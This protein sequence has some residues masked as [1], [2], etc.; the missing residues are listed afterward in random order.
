MNLGFCKDCR[1][2]Q[3]CI[4][5]SVCSHDGKPFVCRPK[6]NS[7]CQY[8]PFPNSEPIAISARQRNWDPL[9]YYR[10]LKTYGFDRIV[11]GLLLRLTGKMPSIKVVPASQVVSQDQ[12]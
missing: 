4:E 11:M 10:Y 6:E 8:S 1:Q 9:E 5:A 12:S 3:E 7:T 2:Y